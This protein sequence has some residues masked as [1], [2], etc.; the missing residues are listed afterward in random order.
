MKHRGNESYIH[1]AREEGATAGGTRPKL[2]E[3]SQMEITD[4]I[5]T[6]VVLWRDLF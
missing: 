2:D 5:P 3:N 6:S 1:L 4:G